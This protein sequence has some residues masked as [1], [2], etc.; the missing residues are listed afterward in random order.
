[1][2]KS[3]ST[4][5]LWRGLLAVAIGV[6]SVAWPDITVGAFVFLFAV[7]AFMAAIADSVRAFTSR[8]AGPVLGYLLLSVLSV[9][10]G[11]GALVWPDITAMV[12]TLWVGAWAFVSGLI[13]VTLAFRRRQ[14]AGER[15]MWLLGGLISIAFGAV[16]AIHPDAG[17]VGLA[18][19]F[20]LYSIVTGLSVIVLSANLRRTHTTAERLIGSAFPEAVTPGR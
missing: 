8:D 4:S 13:E 3:A 1:M 16:V 15:L 2:F 6:V 18:T 17:A 19:V 7:Y 14:P 9:A 20:G 12:L 10:A 5:L 11:I